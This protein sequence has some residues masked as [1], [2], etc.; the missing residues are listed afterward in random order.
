MTTAQ[1]LPVLIDWAN[2]D[3]SQDATIWQTSFPNSGNQVPGVFAGEDK[4]VNLT[5]ATSLGGVV[6]NDGWAVR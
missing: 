6:T 5:P 2:E 1:R 3:P 4:T